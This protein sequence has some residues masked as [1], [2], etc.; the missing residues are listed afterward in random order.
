MKHVKTLNE[1]AN[2]PISSMQCRSVKLLGI[3][4]LNFLNLD[5]NKLL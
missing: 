4:P 1:W 2:E 3:F 5:V